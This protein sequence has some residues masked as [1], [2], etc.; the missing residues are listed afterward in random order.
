MEADKADVHQE[1]ESAISKA[2]SQIGWSG[3]LIK[4]KESLYND[5]QGAKDRLKN[6][7]TL[8]NGSTLSLF[9]NPELVQDIRALRKTL[10]LATNAGVKQESNREVN[11]PDFGKVHYDEDAIVNIFGFSDLK[12]KHRIT[13]DSNKEDAFLIHMDNEL[14]KFECSMGYTNIWYQRIISNSLKE[15]GREDS[16]SNL[17]SAVIE[18]RQGY[19]LRQY[20]RVKEARRLYHI[21]GTPAVNNFKSLLRMNAIQNCPV[22]VE[23]INISEKIFGPDISS[24]KGK[25]VRGK[26]K[27]VRQ[28]LIEIPKELIRKH[29]N[30]ELCMDTIYVNECGKLTAFY[31][32][33]SSEAWSQ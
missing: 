12:K 26:P 16:I 11:I 19:T 6:C 33:S 21:V 4:Q 9:S 10:P 5:D 23:D 32:Q 7:I 30:I 3:L 15:D 27:P 8:D 31:R 1:N 18:S 25:L 29:H 24:L 22:T 20:E 2:S 13:Y 28:D 17:I 14:I